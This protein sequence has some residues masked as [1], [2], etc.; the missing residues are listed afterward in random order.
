LYIIGTKEPSSLPL[1]I[2]PCKTFDYFEQLL[3]FATV[4][5]NLFQSLEVCSCYGKSYIEHG[6]FQVSDDTFLEEEPAQ[7]IKQRNIP[8]SYTET[9]TGS[10]TSRRV[11]TIWELILPMLQPPLDFDFPEQLPLPSEL[12]NF[13]KTGVTFLLNNKGALLGDEMGTG[14][15]VITCVAMQVL[16]QQGY[17]QRAL[18][19]SPKTVL[20]VWTEHLPKWTN[21]QFTL[22]TGSVERRETDW[23][24]PAHVY[25]VT[26]DTLRSDVLGDAKVLMAN[27]IEKFDLVVVDDAHHIKNPKAGR[28]RAVK[29][30][31]PKYR[32]AMTGT[33]IQN[34]LEDL[35][36]IFDFIKPNY[37]RLEGLTPSRAKELIKPYFRRVEKKDVIT[38]L[39][40]KVRTEQWLELDDDQLAEY[41]AAEEREFAEIREKGDTVT[42]IHIF[43][44]IQKLKQICNFAKN[45]ETSA[46][47]EFVVESVENIAKSGKK[48]LIFTQY[49]T[50]GV[51]KLSKLLAPFGVVTITGQS[52]SNQRNDAIQRF[53][54]DQD[55]HVFL[56]AVKA[57]GEGITLI[58][59]TYVIH[60]DHWWNPAVMWQ[61]E[62]RAHRRGQ[63]ET[64][65]VYSLW[66]RDTID[67]RILKILKRKGLLHQEVVAGLSEKEFDKSI[68]TE[69]WLEVL[70]IKPKG[71]SAEEKFKEKPR[72]SVEEV[73]AKLEECEP[74]RFEE[75]IKQLFQK[76]GY[77]NA[78]T[79]KQTHDGGI[80]IEA[81][82][83]IAGGSERIIVQCKRRTATVGEEVARELLGVLT[84]NRAI[85]KGFLVVSGEVSAKCRAFCEHDGRLACLSGVEVANY[86]IQFDIPV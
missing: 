62:D 30:F 15:T 43:A 49:I 14:K 64:L 54:T 41:K 60:F 70:G 36:A 42:K 59:A 6:L 44:V 58:E 22:V 27:E 19:V 77:P 17:V 28:A 46:K 31:N 39:P 7:K 68:S 69:E 63:H 35:V 82:R 9:K 25:L 3:A 86:L 12:Y 33:P 61:A 72:M 24:C 47:S 4:T 8:K 80:D 78:R 50:Q 53:R 1:L 52:S 75:I 55:T 67:E 5:S 11:L 16:F 32:W 57:A 38:D 71:V 81:S 85:S 74:L 45:Q 34:T 2:E 79:T 13:Q 84:A 21:L 23:H 66:M 29:V 26:Y 40:P 83:R 73:L 20:S 18:V 76:L 65:N 10:V 51:E 48:V 56:A 37:L